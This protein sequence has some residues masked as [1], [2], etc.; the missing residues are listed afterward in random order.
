M[1]YPRK[2]FVIRKVIEDVPSVENSTTLYEKEE[3]FGLTW[4][5]LYG[6]ENGYLSLHLMLD[7]DLLGSW[8]IETETSLKLISSNG[9]SSI[10]RENCNFRYRHHMWGWD[11]FMSWSTLL[12]SYMVNRKVTVEAHVVIK[13]MIG[14]DRKNLRKFD[15]SVRDVSDVV[16]VVKDRRFYLCKEILA[17]QSTYFRSILFGNNEEHPEIEFHDIDPEDFQAFL[18]LLH[19]ESSVDDSTVEGI[20]HLAHVYNTPMCV[21]R[22][23]EFLI[24][25]SKFKLDKKLELSLRYKLENLKPTCISHVTSVADVREIVSAEIREMDLHTS[26][27]LLR[28]LLIICD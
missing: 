24:E 15:E 14:L 22:C 7:S 2:E 20:L 13:E 6:H 16:V 26:Q 21:R 17:V 10:I 28:K 18:E 27:A 3:H 12:G 11:D 23:E 4:K 9:T 1:E 25:K 5:F 8:S 19:G